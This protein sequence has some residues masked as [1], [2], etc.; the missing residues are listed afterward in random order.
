MVVRIGAATL[1]AAG[2][3]SLSSPASAQDNALGGALIG[4]AAGAVVGGAVSGRA[5]GA[6]V[7]TVIGAAAGAM[8][9]SQMELRRGRYYW[10]DNR[11]WYRYPSGAFRA[12]SARHCR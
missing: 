10:Y 3:F 6:A 2:I 7:G 4:G 8:I 1:I 5:G 11:C 9:G 12:V